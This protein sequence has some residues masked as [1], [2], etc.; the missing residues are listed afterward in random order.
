[1]DPHNCRSRHDDVV[2]DGACLQ[3][4]A[5]A[6]QSQGAG[7]HSM[8]GSGCRAPEC[9]VIGDPDRAS[10]GAGNVNVARLVIHHQRLHMTGDRV[11]AGVMLQKPDADTGV[12]A[13]QRRN[14]EASC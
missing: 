11:A 2:A 14:N 8:R 6:V 3:T 4:W 1:M 7:G 5:A 12:T 10:V 13:G 9:E